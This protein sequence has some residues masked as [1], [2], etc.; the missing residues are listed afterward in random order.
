MLVSILI[1][2][3]YFD[4]FML[5]PLIILGCSAEIQKG[6]SYDEKVDCF[7]FGLTL[8]AMSLKSDLI[9]FVASRWCTAF[10]KLKAPT[11]INRFVRAMSDDGWR[12]VSLDS[13]CA[14]PLA[15]ATIT[16]LVVAC[17]AHDAAARPSFAAVLAELMGPCAEEVARFRDDAADA[18]SPQVTDQRDVTLPRPSRAIRDTQA[19]NEIFESENPLRVS[20]APAVAQTYRGAFEIEKNNLSC[21]NA[22]SQNA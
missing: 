16:A 15:P 18:A 17:C 22:A 14:I 20:G 12:P 2:T 21:V 8:L 13:D 3:N 11:N 1:V 4:V 7:S 6:E 19:R 9:E 10:N 5:I